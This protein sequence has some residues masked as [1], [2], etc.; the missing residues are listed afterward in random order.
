[1]RLVHSEHLYL[2]H[3]NAALCLLLYHI[4]V[5]MHMDT[6]SREKITLTIVLSSSMGPTTWQLGLQLSTQEVHAGLEYLLPDWVKLVPVY[7]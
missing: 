6:E 5:C 7:Q 4:T 2:L 1:M 3:R